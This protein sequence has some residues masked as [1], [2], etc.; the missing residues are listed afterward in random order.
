MKRGNRYSKGDR[1][2][3]LKG[4][5]V[6]PTIVKTDML[7]DEEVFGPV[8][9][10]KKFKTSDEAVM[11]ANETPY[12][13]GASIW[14]DP[15]EAEKL[16]PHIQAGMVF[17]NKVVASDPRLPFGG[18]KKSGMGSELSRYGLLEFTTKRTVW[19]T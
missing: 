16:A 12:G 5:F 19:I 4:N 18:V 3:E 11:L 2:E 8:A 14:G 1:A 9:I 13:L 10:F 7:F 17:I 6:P 15:D